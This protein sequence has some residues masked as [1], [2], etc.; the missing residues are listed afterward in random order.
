[1]GHKGEAVVSALGGNGGISGRLWHTQDMP[2]PT[3]ESLIDQVDDLDEP[4]GLVKKKDIFRL[5]VGFRVAHILVRDEQGNLLLEHLSAKAERSPLRLGSTSA[6]YLNAGE[7]YAEAARRRL[8]EERDSDLP[9]TKLGCI[10]MP[11]QG[12]TK[13]IGVFMATVPRG[14]TFSFREDTE[15]L[16]WFSCTEIEALLVE[17]EGAF[18]T[19]FPYVY[20]LYRAVIVGF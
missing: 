13:F 19:T 6:G 11:D 20:R 5:G 10:R 14:T 15:E 3:P 2:A 7:G 9:L 17:D 8:S 4:I 16:K 18:T 1:M 12:A